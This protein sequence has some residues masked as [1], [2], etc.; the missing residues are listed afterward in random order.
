MAASNTSADADQGQEEQVAFNDLH[1]CDL[2]GT[3]LTVEDCDTAKSWARKASPGNAA[4]KAPTSMLEGE[5]KFITLAIGKGDPAAAEDHPV[6]SAPADENTVAIADGNETAGGPAP[7]PSP[8]ATP[9]SPTAEVERIDTGKGQTVPYR[10]YVGQ[11]MRATLNG[12]GAFDVVALTPEVQSISDDS[13]TVWRWSVQAKRRGTLPLLLSTAVVM[14]DSRGGIQELKPFTTTQN[15]KV[16]IGPA[17]VY[18]WLVGTPAWL[19]AITGILTAL[20][21]LI[22]AWRVLRGRSAKAKDSPPEPGKEEP[23]TD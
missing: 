14:V 23:P 6:N 7:P 5:T 16:N 20:A 19:K 2:T 13:L 11:R 17:T 18:S 22:A 15:V 12:Q 3:R 9:L 4:F 21:A 10:P 1:P 8:A